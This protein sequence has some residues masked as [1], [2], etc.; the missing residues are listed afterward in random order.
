MA[1]GARSRGHRPLIATE[2]TA[3]V[4]AGLAAGV[5]TAYWC[6][7]YGRVSCL[8]WMPDDPLV[9]Q[10]CCHRAPERARPP[11]QFFPRF[12]LTHRFHFARSEGESLIT[13]H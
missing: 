13:D 4:L 12:A 1:L 5:A 3:V 9:F 7:R 8:D 10:Y 2:M 11:R 6:G